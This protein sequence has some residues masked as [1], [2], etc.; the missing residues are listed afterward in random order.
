MTWAKSYWSG[1]LLILEWGTACRAAITVGFARSMVCT[2][3]RDSRTP[4]ATGARPHK[5]VPAVRHGPP[6]DG[7]PPA[8]VPPGRPVLLLRV[9]CGGVQAGP[10]AEP[11]ARAGAAAPAGAFHV[12]ENLPDRAVVPSKQVSQLT[13]LGN[14]R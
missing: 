13:Q 14:V 3:C 6:D 2:M 1:A 10:Q 8:A 5:A 12:Q 11:P 4:L 9:L 7:V